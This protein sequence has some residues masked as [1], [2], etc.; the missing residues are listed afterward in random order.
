MT[1][2]VLDAF[3]DTS[4]WT[5]VTSGLAQLTISSE[6]VAGR[7]AMRLDYD[8]KGGG[9]FVVARKLLP[10]PI[11]ETY[12]FRFAIRG[13]APANR[14]EIKLADPSGRNVWWRHWD[15]FE[16]TAD[17]RTM[18]V[19]S[20]EIE[21]AWGPAGGGALSQLGA[22]EFVIAAGP[23][24]AGTVWISDL[25]LED[26]TYRATPRVRASS[27]RIGHAPEYALDGDGTTSWRGDASA[28][29]QWLEI[30]FQ[31]EREYG[32][33]VVQWAPGASPRTFDVQISN[34]GA[35]WTTVHAAEAADV[36]CSYIY[37][38][39][40]AGRYVR[41][42][43]EPQDARGCGIVEVA[44]QPFEFSRSM[45]AFFE[46]VA[47]SQPRGYHPRWLCGEQSYWTCVGLSDGETCAIINEEGAVEV[48]RGTFVIE[49]FVHV[50]GR[51][52]TWADAEVVQTLEDDWL[53]IPSSVWNAEELVVRTTA[54]A[55]RWDGYAILYVRYRI[56]NRAARVRQARVF[57]AIRPFQ[58]NPPWQAFGELGGVRKIGALAWDGTAVQVDASRWV[59][60][61]TV[62]SGFG[63]AAFER[64]E[65]PSY[66]ARGELPSRSSVADA[67]GYASGALAFDVDLAP[68]AAGDVFLAIPFGA[69]AAATVAELG[70]V[71]GAEAFD[72]A[73]RD[74][75]ERLGAVGFTLPLAARA[76]GDVAR[77]AAAQVLVNRDGPALQPGPRRYTRSWIRDGAV[78]AAA[79]LR[80]GRCSEAVE[81]VR[82]YAG[83]QAADGNVPCCVDRNGPDWLVEH[84]SHGELIYTVME[85][86]RFTRD[87]AFLAELWPAVRKAVAYL[88]ALRAQRLGPAFDTPDLRARRGLLPESASHEGYLA[89]PVH[90]YWD[91]FWALQGYRD[92]A[93]MAALLGEDGEAQRIAASHDAL[94]LAVR[95]SIACTMAE[96]G[97]AYV[98]GSV[99]WA[100]FDPAATAVAVSLLGALEDL[101]RQA[102]EHSF[103]EYLAGFRRRQRGEI[104]W[105]NYSA[106][107]IR[108]IGALVHL[109]RR[110]DVA[111]LAAS[112]LGD[113]RPLVWNQWP[114]ISW[115]NP[116]SPG[117]LG[118]VPHTWIGAEYVFAFRTMLAYERQSDQALVLAAGVPAAWVDDATGV[119][120][121]HLP[122]H[123]G[124]LDFHLRREGRNLVFTIG[125]AIEMPPG[126]IVLYPPLAGPLVA[127]EVNGRAISIGEADGVMIDV[128][129]ARVVLR[130]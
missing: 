78:M 10:Q 111:A 65:I 5:A 61:L 117:H 74:W 83:Y 3:E 109:G 48:D 99:E 70:Q 97:I 68:G 80:F 35:S 128:C 124:T 114:E 6:R 47:R 130:I 64:G 46:H 31:E 21:F 103:D 75:R 26:R 79:L 23:G 52:L 90:A 123:Y 95:A 100:D 55:G 33:L 39:C 86:F 12:A 36:E 8:F 98:P 11:P 19:R 118:D 42:A 63:A 7:Q 16:L 122:T 1:S 43:L 44:V 107:E 34:D 89:H 32:G 116:R 120:V 113:R 54:F 104:D 129:P 115:R 81:F 17:W 58:V 92:A 38:P 51:L 112:L 60:P 66:L 20:S 4:R 24:G 119:G 102:L 56:E 127:V 91:D 108:I 14:F 27:A 62:P 94:R 71:D 85:C 84:D 121:T 110:N 50:D 28:A 93:A 9:G 105:N 126:G 45:H 2:K 30:D 67:F 29:A 18:D 106:Y 76:Y 59:V 25:R 37:L 87:R 96:R 53:P 13:A 41:F 77:T 88:D 82:W 49:P 73:L 22:I 40:T 57:A 15:A 101:P 72:T 125:G 69:A